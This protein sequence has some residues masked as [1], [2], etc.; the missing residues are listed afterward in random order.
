MEALAVSTSVGPLPWHGM[1][2]QLYGRESR[3]RLNDGWIKKYNT[4]WVG[5]RPLR[6]KAKFTQVK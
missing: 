6:K 4:R 5:P 1:D 2:A 3:P